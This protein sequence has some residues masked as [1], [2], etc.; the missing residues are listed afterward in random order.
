MF[1]YY[2]YNVLSLGFPYVIKIAVR[3][4]IIEAAHQTAVAKLA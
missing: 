2:V 3:K 1:W 4:A